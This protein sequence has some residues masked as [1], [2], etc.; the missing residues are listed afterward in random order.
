MFRR[1]VFFFVPL[2]MSF[3][4]LGKNKCIIFP[5]KKKKTE[6]KS[7]LPPIEPFP[8]I[9]VFSPIDFS[10][11][12][13]PFLACVIS[14]CRSAFNCVLLLWH[15]VQLANLGGGVARRLMHALESLVLL[16]LLLMQV[17]KIEPFKDVQVLF[18]HRCSGCWR[19]WRSLCECEL[20]SLC[21]GRSEGFE[22]GPG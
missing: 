3:H 18:D 13:G 16:I 9:R 19:S 21:S 20:H 11:S 17:E 14:L 4:S 6:E 2:S 15:N 22:V 12:T 10:P 8:C 1:Q 7:G 5:F